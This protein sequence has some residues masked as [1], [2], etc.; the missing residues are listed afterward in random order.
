MSQASHRDPTLLEDLEL[1]QNDVLDQ[2]DDLERRVESLLNEFL[3]ARS[4][5]TV[6]EA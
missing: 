6:A 4:V 5:T 2:L 3:T 1:R